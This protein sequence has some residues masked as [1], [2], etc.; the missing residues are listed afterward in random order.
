MPPTIEVRD[1]A[2]W[3]VVC[4]AGELDVYTAPRLREELVD[5]IADGCRR[6]I[7]D[8]NGVTFIDST[9]LGV[10]V[11]ILKRMRTV[12]GEL[13][14]IAANEPVLRTMRITGLQ[15][16]LCTHPTVADATATEFPVPAPLT[17]HD[18]SPARQR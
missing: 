6:L 12:D 3:T 1:G 10:L 18:A 4:V 8:M 16:V 11:G 9:G 2:G 5:V 15:R 14:V 7:V 13:R 17:T